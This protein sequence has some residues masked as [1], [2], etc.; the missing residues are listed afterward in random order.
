MKIFLL[1]FFFTVSALAGEITLKE[2]MGHFDTNSPFM[3]RY[4]LEVE[5]FH[6]EE[7]GLR[8]NRN[9]RVDY[10]G[11][12]LKESYSDYERRRYYD[13]TERARFSLLYDDFY[14]EAVYD[15]EEEEAY[16]NDNGSSL[17]ESRIGIQKSLNDLIYS[18]DDFEKRYIEI[19]ERMVRNQL[20][21]EYLKEAEKVIDSYGEILTLQQAIE[22]DR[23]HLEEYRKLYEIAVKKNQVGEGL[24]LEA[25]YLRAE[26][27]E[28][29]ER[30]IYSGATK[31][32]RVLQLAKDIGSPLAGDTPIENFPYMVD[33][34]LRVN[35]Y[36]LKRAVEEGAMIE[37]ERRLEERR[38]E[39]EFT[40]GGDYDTQRELW[41]LRFSLEGSIFDYPLDSSLKESDGLILKERTD[42]LRERKE[43]ELKALREEY[44][45]LKNNLR[46]KKLKR[47]NRERTVDIMREMYGMGYITS[48]KFIEEK[49][50]A[51][52]AQMEYL[53]VLNKLGAFKFKMHLRDRAASL[54][55]FFLL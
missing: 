52:D 48:K 22:V 25:D 7:T 45:H 38:E 21:Y 1:Y 20:N 11:E 15:F 53:E 5:R 13:D 49:R 9:Q 8:K 50:D 28:V 18:E 4:R 35:D 23:E 16:Y 47:D 54:E 31:E 24:K 39:T 37:E 55:E 14:Y 41:S 51:R 36:D 26:V 43:S 17:K 19:R 33:P 6:R 44:I 40:M 42:Q 2:V 34:I 30:T 46:I 29:E 12:L 32:V 10:S 3:K 27:M